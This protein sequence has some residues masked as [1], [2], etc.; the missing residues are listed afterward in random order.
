MDK[1]GK[2]ILTPG[3]KMVL[4][5][6]MFSQDDMIW[7]HKKS[8]DVTNNLKR[9]LEDGNHT[10]ISFNKGFVLFKEDGSDIIVSAFCL[11]PGSKLTMK[12]AW[13]IF[14][15]FVRENGFNKIR[16][17]T[18][19][20]PE[21]WTKRWGFKLVELAKSHKRWTEMEISV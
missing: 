7:Y 20:N 15:I 8:K 5:P 14:R 16:I 21:G 6:P 11:F 3:I 13:A 19:R 4:E 1:W 12:R 2:Y 18:Q 10:Y 9:I 17:F